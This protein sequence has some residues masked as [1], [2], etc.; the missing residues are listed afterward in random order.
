MVLMLYHK[1]YATIYHS[2]TDDI[3]ISTEQFI[4]LILMMSCS[5]TAIL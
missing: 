4:I 5:L 3:L 1:F 2:N